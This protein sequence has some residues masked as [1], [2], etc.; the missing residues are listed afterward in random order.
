[1]NRSFAVTPARLAIAAALVTGLA[2]CGKVAD[3]LG[4]KAVE[5]AA[6]AAIEASI[7]KDGAKI[8]V[9]MSEGTG[10][11]SGV[12]EKGRPML[13]EMG[14]AKLGEAELKMPF[15]PG[16][17]PVEHKSN[18]MLV[19]GRWLMQIEFDSKD[20]AAV[21]A[22]WYL[23]R[24]KDRMGAGSVMMN[25]G[26]GGSLTLMVSDPAKDTMF[27]VEVKGGDE[28]SQIVLQHGFKDEGK[29]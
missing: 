22:E 18:R 8:K 20:K 10:K 26:E 25:R 16:A 23:A 28:G 4:E 27:M 11:M 29:T 5:K 21:V 9:D 2:G 13:M 3:K 24:L 7:N 19:D 1:M 12:D 17:T 6:E 15:Y 14:G